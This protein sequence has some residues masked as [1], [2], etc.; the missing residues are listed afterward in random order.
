MR[1]IFKGF[2]MLRLLAF[3]PLLVII[4]VL[5]GVSAIG[6]GD[7][8][9]GIAVLAGVPLVVMAG[10]GRLLARRAGQPHR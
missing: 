8:V 5:V 6:R 3:I 9:L 1:E 4:A 7:E 2:L 10:L